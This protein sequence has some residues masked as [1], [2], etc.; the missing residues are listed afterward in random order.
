MV[1]NAGVLLNERTL[2]SEGV[3]TTFASHF[4]FGSY[5]LGTLL[6][7]QIDPGEG[8]IIF[9]SSGGM[10]NTKFPSWTRATSTGDAKSSYSGNMSYSYAKRGQVLLAER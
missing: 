6:M 8:C 10:Y 2:T 1:C 9:V 5:M 3:E 4:L 7:P